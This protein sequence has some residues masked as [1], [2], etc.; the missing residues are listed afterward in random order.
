MKQKRNYSLTAKERKQKRMA[1]QNKQ[2]DGKSYVSK[3][4]VEQKSA[5]PELSAEAQMAKSQTQSKRMTIIVGCVIGVAILLIIAALLAPVIMHVVNPYRGYDDV[6]A[7]FTLSN[8]ME[9]EYV[10][11]EDEYDTTAT[12]FIFL[13][14]NKYFDNTVFYDAQGGWLRF[15]GYVDQPLSNNTSDYK[16]SNH[17]SDSEDYCKGFGA[18]PNNRFSKVTEKF[19]YRLYTRPDDRNDN[20]VKQLGTLTYRT[21]TATEFQFYYGDY[22][23]TV[24]TN[25][26]NIECAMVGHAL[27]EQTKKNL[28][29]I[30]AMAAINSHLSD[31][32]LW[33]PPTP[34]I[35][36]ESV[37]VYNLNSSKWADFDFLKYLEGKDSDGNQ[38]YTSWYGKA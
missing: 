28:K 31:G 10:I 29:S 33:K 25:I 7:K 18:L 4:T 35:R 19:G 17:R 23:E 9:L 34:N 26:S 22:T 3:P 15:G 1:E 6:I 21:D 30:R 14:N 32:Y 27:N 13:A 24:P 12:N 2:A 8:G 36:I 5:A 11:D 20:L 37:K 38:R 16:R